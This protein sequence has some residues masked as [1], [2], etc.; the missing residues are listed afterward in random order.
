[1]WFDVGIVQIASRKEQVHPSRETND[2]LIVS[3]QAI[4]TLSL[5][6]TVCVGIPLIDG[7]AR[8]RFLRD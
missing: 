3:T 7:L 8:R 4:H 5:P 2:M 1:M 6:V